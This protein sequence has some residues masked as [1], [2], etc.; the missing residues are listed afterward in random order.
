MLQILREVRPSLISWYERE[1]REMP[2]RSDP[3]PYHVYVSEIM[4]QQTRVDTVRPYYLRF[5]A[6]LPDIAALASCE[7]SRL[8]KLWE[9]LGYYSRVRSMK[10]AAGKI[11]E[12]YGGKI[13][14]SYSELLKLPGIGAYTAGAVSSIAF[15]EKEAVVDGNVLRVLSRLTGSEDNIDLDSTRENYR[16][17]LKSFLTEDGTDPAVFNQSLMELGAL[18]CVPNAEPRCEVCPLASSCRAFRENRTDMLPVRSPKIPR[19]KAEITCFLIFRDSCLL[20]VKNDR[21]RLLSGLY[22]LPHYEGRPDPGKTAAFLSSIG[23]E[24]ESERILP[25]RKHIFTH[26]EWQMHGIEILT[27]SSPPSAGSGYRFFNSEELENEAAVPEA[28]RK[29][30]LK[31][32]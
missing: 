26:I 24:S 3:T 21:K 10:K 27:K 7:E 28:Y 30:G 18:V 14:S 16:K 15:H 6:E 2:W 1:K 9:G 17:L 12:K 25:D 13:P 22:A 11:V 8:L 4:L 32:H 31:A 29:W 23:I 19:K 5:I 20:L